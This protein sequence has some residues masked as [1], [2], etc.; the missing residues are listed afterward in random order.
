MIGAKNVFMPKTHLVMSMFRCVGFTHDSLSSFIDGC[1]LSGIDG[2]ALSGLH[3]FRAA[4]CWP[5][6]SRAPLMLLLLGGHLQPL[7]VLCFGFVDRKRSL[8]P[9]VSK[10]AQ[11]CTRDF[12]LPRLRRCK[13]HLDAHAR[14]CILFHPKVR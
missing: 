1:A 8:H 4:A 14:N 2:C 11:L 12:I 13:P 3:S 6:A 9:V 5:C 10:T 7:I